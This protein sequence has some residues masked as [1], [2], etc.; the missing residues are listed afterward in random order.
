M[1]LGA[2]LSWVS[3]AAALW[4]QQGLGTAANAV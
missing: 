4:S 1:V 3:P 2:Q